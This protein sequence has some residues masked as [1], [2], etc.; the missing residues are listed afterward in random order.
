[1]SAEEVNVTGEQLVAALNHVLYGSDSP[2]IDTKQLL[3]ANEA[4]TKL[5]NNPVESVDM[6]GLTP[7]ADAVLN[8]VEKVIGSRSRSKKIGYDTRLISAGLDS[9]LAI[10][11]SKLLKEQV[12]LSVSVFEIM[13]GAS[14]RDIV[15]RPSSNKYVKKDPVQKQS[16][17]D[18]G[19]IP[20][21]AKSLGLPDSCI[22][23]VFPTLS[24][25][26][27]HLEQWVHNGKRFFEPPWVYTVDSS[28]TE[29]KVKGAWE[30]LVGAHDILRTT[31]ACGGNGQG[32]FQVT[33]NREWSPSKRFSA[34]R[35]LSQTIES[36]IHEH[37]DEQNLQVSNFKEPPARFSFLEASNGKALVL[38]LHHALYD[39]WSIKMIEKDLD[40]LLGT[41]KLASDQQPLVRVIEQVN[42]V[43]HPEAEAEYWRQ[44]LSRADDTIFGPG[45][46]TTA[47]PL[48]PQFKSTFATK[49]APYT[50]DYVS[51]RSNSEVSAAIILAYARAL[52][53]RMMNTTKPTFGL[54]HASRSLSSRDGSQT[55]DLTASSLPTLTVTP[56]SVDQDTVTQDQL[57]SVRDH[58]AQLTCF[59]QADGISKMSPAFNTYLNI[60]HRKESAQPEE[61]ETALQRYRLPESLA[62]S[63]FTS[64]EPSSTV[65]T[66]DQLDT[67]H[68]CAHRLFVNVIVGQDREVKIT[69][70]ADEGVLAG[71]RGIID[72][73]VHCFGENLDE[74]VSEI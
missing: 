30:E 57:S 20:A 25:Q 13:K 58:L 33:L 35:D 60:I 12:G 63:Y 53:Q 45:N 1:M 66:V 74:V 38:R 40:Q 23:S 14:V 56:L 54:N 61:S 42:N 71:D 47:S 27:S 18:E 50:I 22:Q 64:T 16:V 62:S 52:H 68:L 48:G 3:V 55:L 2:V 36:L 7:K 9:I 8:V 19:L 72:R 15:T 65:S 44:Y 41:G 21:M 46:A 34:I 70:S 31:F 11:L 51:Q 5:R 69:V 4:V 39:A 67:S 73:L 59:A 17:V 49:L 32:L 6:N 29:E 28:F 43:R 24:G 10:R 26:R 37:V